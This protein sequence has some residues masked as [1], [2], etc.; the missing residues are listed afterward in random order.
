MELTNGAGSSRSELA[1]ACSEGDYE[2]AKELMAIGCDPITSRA[3]YFSW[4]PLHYTARQGKLDF[5]QMLISQYSCQPQVEDKEGRTPLHVACQYGQL[6]FARYLIQQKRCDA[7]YMD[8]EDQTPLHHTCGWLSECVEEQALAISQ[9]L[10]TKAKCDPNTRDVNGKTSVLHACEKGFLSVLKYFV[11]ECN[12]DLSVVDYKGNNALHLAVSFSNSFAVVDFIM[13]KNVVNLKAVNNSENNILHMAAIAKS[14]L[15][16]CKL[17]LDQTKSTSLIESL[18][19]NGLTP[20]DLANDEL[21]HYVLTRFQIHSDKFYKKYA[22]SLGVK[23]SPLPQMRV[24]VVGNSRSGKT[25]LINSLQ[26]EMTS[27]SLSFSSH[28]PISQLVEEV[29]G[30]VVTDYDSRQYGCVTFYDFSGH[31]DYEYIQK[32]L[33]RHS[34]CPFFSIF[35][36]V[37]DQRKPNQDMISSIHHWLSVVNGAWTG[38]S[39]EKLRVIIAGSHADVVKSSSKS[40][41]GGLKSVSLDSLSSSFASFEFVSKIQIDCQKTDHSGMVSLRRQL[42]TVCSTMEGTNSISFNASCLLAYLKSR[43]HSLP[44]VTLE[45]LAA[46]IASYKLETGTVRDVRYFLSKDVSILMRLLSSLDDAGHLHLLKDEAEL[47]KSVV[48]IQ[49]PEVFADLTK[50]WNRGGMSTESADYH[51]LLPHSTMSAVYPDLDSDTLSRI[52]TSLELC[53]EIDVHL[54]TSATERTKHFYFPSM[55]SNSTPLY[56]WDPRCSYEHNY[57]WIIEG[58]NRTKHFS[59][60]FVHVVLSRCLSASSFGMADISLWRNGVYFRSND[61]GIME[62]LV[63]ASDDLNSLVLLMRTQRF[64]PSFLQ[65]RSI[66]TKVIR[67]EFL[68]EHGSS[69]ESLVDPFEAMHYPLPNRENLTLFAVSHI[70]S[71][72]QSGDLKYRLN[73]GIKVPLNDIMYFDPFLFIGNDCLCILAKVQGDSISDE[74][75]RSMAQVMTL[76]I[77]MLQLFSHIFSFSQ[78]EFRPSSDELYCSLLSWN[79]NSDQTYTD[80][81][82][83]LESFSV[84]SGTDILNFVT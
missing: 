36:V 47:E 15:D 78:T 46:N 55:L 48:L 79:K 1:I 21:I 19:E 4:S 84:F 14:S 74:F 80:L 75:F 5:A 10:V 64:N 30:L 7:N 29:R 27:F 20:L 2:R 69:V 54:E 59:L 71:S 12:S 40:Q 6:E 11:E 28:S 56:V 8:V 33:L 66:I 31:S 44:A 65:H 81:V 49:A 26:K 57:G 37:V 67:R 42:S 50:L 45:T 52:L 22:V 61:A 41:R 68:A 25:A 23:Q 16:I 43:F 24:F 13:S 77:E 63:Q 73:C 51:S 70:I 38:K 82:Q 76:N 3:G 39:G 34:I 60:N 35:V 62:V 53:T 83:L 32:C 58:C 9:Y 17:I 18:N 72:I